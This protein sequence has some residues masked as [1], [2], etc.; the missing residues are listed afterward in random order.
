MHINIRIP[1]LSTVID[2]EVQTLKNTK[3][4]FST[5]WK[6]E[7]EEQRL[8]PITKWSDI[9]YDNLNKLNKTIANPFE[10]LASLL[11]ESN[12]LNIS[13]EPITVKIPMIF[14]EDINAYSIYLQQRLST[15][16]EI[17]NRWKAILKDSDLELQL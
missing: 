6:N 2:Q 7:D 16:E 9:S 11:N 13:V 1:D 4:K 10:S 5:I 12:I 3:E 14:A 15:N 17:F 8:K